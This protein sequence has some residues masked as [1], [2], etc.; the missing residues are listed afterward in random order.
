MRVPTE[1]RLSEWLTAH[2]Q[3][4]QYWTDTSSGRIF[5][6]FESHQHDVS[7]LAESYSPA[8]ALLIAAGSARRGHAQAASLVPGYCRRI[9]ELLADENTPAFTALF[10]QYFGLLAGTDLK[11]LASQPDAPISPDQA[12]SFVQTLCAWKDRLETPINAN[13]AAMQAGVQMLRQLHAQQADWSLCK[14]RLEIVST[15][16]SDSGLINDDLA[17]PSM[18]IAYHM[19]CMYLLAGAMCRLDPATRPAEAAEPLRC[20]DAIVSRGYAWLGH[21]LA[22]DGMIAQYGRSRYHVFSQAAGVALLAAA[23]LEAEDATVRRYLAWMDHYR[24][25]IEGPEGTQSTI[26]AVTPNL[27][28]PAIRVG[29]ETYGMVTVY[30]NLAMAILLDAL[31]WWT[32]AMPLISAAGEARRTFFNTARERGCHADGQAGLVR[33]RSRAGFVLV[34]LQTDYRGYTPLGSL[35][36]LRLG[37]DL[38]ERAVAPPFWAD[39]RVQAEA[40][41]MGVWEGPLVCDNTRENCNVAH[42]PAFVMQGRTLECQSSQSSLVL[43]C[44]GPDADWA[45]TII[46]EPTALQ[47]RWQVR[48][49]VAG[50]MLFAVVP[51][52]L[53]N[54]LAQARLRFDG[55]QVL[56][57][58]DGRTW[59]LTIADS[60]GQPLPG[61]WFLTPYR[62]TASTSGVTGRLLFPLSDSTEA[63]RTIEWTVRIEAV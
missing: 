57:S 52:L 33:L 21:L 62:S 59:R 1:H 55:A 8:T 46:L 6:P 47:L 2:L 7:I 14:Q 26:F 3:N 54:G 28:P 9:G 51:C 45:K 61:A 12:N 60:Q 24:L 34:N 49:D 37:D 44:K 36:H 38:H 18:P 5:D 20:A 4:L 50:Q 32:G 63:G 48:L 10:L 22:N 30:N 29:F 43:R 11:A 53:W 39:P 31:A 15:Q 40:P 16:Q 41:A 19:F 42:P 56:A 17:G 35:V 58:L 27:C 25:P 23:G 13:C